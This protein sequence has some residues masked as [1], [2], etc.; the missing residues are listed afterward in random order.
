MYEII[1]TILFIIL[2]YVVCI[3]STRID[4]LTSDKT[5]FYI[6]YTE[7]I[8]SVGKYLEASNEAITNLGQRAEL[9]Y[10]AQKSLYAHVVYLEQQLKEL[11]GACK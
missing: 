11:Q 3:Q 5:K 9:S 10:E 1:L 2:T 4:D 8:E 7:Y 6:K